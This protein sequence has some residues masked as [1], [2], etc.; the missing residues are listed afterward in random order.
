MYSSRAASQH[1]LG[2]YINLLRVK[3]S[4]TLERA[5]SNEYP[6]QKFS[7]RNKKIALWVSIGLELALNSLYCR[8]ILER[9][10]R[11]NIKIGKHIH[12]NLFD[13]MHLAKGGHNFVT[14]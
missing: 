4:F 10:N 5:A 11:R 6:L 9:N 14:F 8:D 1:V 13:L 7:L 2:R 3:L 12:T